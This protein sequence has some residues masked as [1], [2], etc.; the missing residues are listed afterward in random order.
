[1]ASTVVDILENYGLWQAIARN[2]TSELLVFL[3]E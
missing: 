1:M 3:S 2:S